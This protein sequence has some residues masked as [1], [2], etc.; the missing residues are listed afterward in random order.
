MKIN[1]Y[2]F[3]TEYQPIYNELNL[4]MYRMTGFVDVG[5]SQQL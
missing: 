1:N 2:I 5:T 3:F 4:E